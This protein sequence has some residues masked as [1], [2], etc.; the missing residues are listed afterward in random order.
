[1]YISKTSTGTVEAFAFIQREVTCHAPHWSPAAR[2][3]D[4]FS[5]SF[6]PSHPSS[7]ASVTL[8]LHAPLGLRLHNLGTSGTHGVTSTTTSLGSH[9]DISVTLRF[10][11]SRPHLGSHRQ[12][13]WRPPARADP[14]E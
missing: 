1:M 6:S 5:P 13:P 4:P 3:R 10:T 9:S 8:L 11:C 2:C 7:W 14:F 12:L